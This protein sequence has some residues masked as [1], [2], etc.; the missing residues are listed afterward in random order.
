MKKLKKILSAVLSSVIMVSAIS[1]GNVSFV[2]AAEIN[3]SFEN[4]YNKTVISTD[5]VDFEIIYSDEYKQYL[6]DLENGDVEKYGDIVPPMLPAIPANTYEDD[7]APV[8]IYLPS[9][10][11]PRKTGKT[12]SVK[13]QSSRGLCWD[14]S[15]LA[16]AEQALIKSTE[17]EYDLS[18]NYYNY[19]MAVDALGSSKT[20][21]FSYGTRYLDSGGWAENVFSAMMVQHGPLLETEFPY[22][23]KGA[24]Q[25]TDIFTSK[26]AVYSYAYDDFPA[27]SGDLTTSV[28]NTRVNKIKEAVYENGSCNI[29]QDFSNLYKNYYDST[30]YS[31]YIPVTQSTYLTHSLCIVGWDDSYSKNNFKVTPNHDGAFI[32]KNSWGSGYGESGYY[33]LSY[34]D[35]FIYR[36]EMSSVKDMTDE[37][38][39]DKINYYTEYSPVKTLIPHQD[40]FFIANVYDAEIYTKQQLAAVGIQTLYDNARFEIYVNPYNAT[41]STDSLIKVYSGIAENAGYHTFELDTPVN[42]QSSDGKY[43]VA[44]KFLSD[45]SNDSVYSYIAVEKE[46]GNYKP[47]NNGE[48]FYSATGNSWNDFSSDGMNFYINAYTNYINEYNNDSLSIRFYKPDTWGNNIK[49]HIWDTASSNTT[50]PG[51]VMKKISDGIYQYDNYKIQNCKII[52]NDNNGHQTSD[53]TVSGHVTVIDD[54]VIKRSSKPIEVKFKKPSNWSDDVKIYYYSND[55]RKIERSAWPGEN[56]K[57]IGEGYYSYTITDMDSVRILFTD[58]NYQIPGANQP[59]IVV[60][61]G[62]KLVYENNKYSY[63]DVSTLNILFKKPSSWSNKIYIHMWN[64]QDY[65]TT[66]PGEKMTLLSNGY[67]QYKNS[68]LY[69]CNAVISDS[70]GHQTSDID[71]VGCK[72]FI[73]NKIIDNSEENIKVTF[74]K[75][76]SWGSNIKLYYYTND[77]NEISPQTWPG[78]AME[79]N[80]DGTF[81]YNITD[82]AYVR[83]I[84]T[85]GTNQTPLANRQGYPVIAGQHMIYNN[86]NITYLNL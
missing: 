7:I 12:S 58:G 69:S 52:I 80:G 2:S 46:N 4:L 76:S 56:M 86:G 64:A 79:D 48:S 54:K 41:L 9:K 17:K 65:D 60:N 1:M 81:T 67:Y 23:V 36:S 39:Y 68:N 62:Q 26:P 22:S 34:E 24:L 50:W 19:L 74:Y 43:V 61:A 83:V 78:Y 59:G 73:D 84:F 77:S 53:L 3:D 15:A 10:Y 33:Y 70:K 75:P 29:Y 28:M 21:L 47:A 72:T 18:E 57:N 38:K 63:D 37:A 5:D 31:L 35:Y 44:I 40:T 42:I 49:I 71:L 30:N 25:N 16:G 51:V 14:F 85:D 6:K 8:A 82:M 55:I 20:N 66:W 45:G 27:I 11:D 13:N 32:V